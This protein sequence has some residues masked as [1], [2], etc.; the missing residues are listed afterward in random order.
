MQAQAYLKT[1]SSIVH[2]VLAHIGVFPPL[3]LCSATGILESRTSERAEMTACSSFQ[4]WLKRFWNVQV[5][6]RIQ[7]SNCIFCRCPGSNCRAS[8]ELFEVA[9]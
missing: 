9:R 7:M 3:L 2:L 1:P 8:P 5:P 4:M 6:I